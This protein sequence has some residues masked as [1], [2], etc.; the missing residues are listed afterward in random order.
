MD[1]VEDEVGVGPD[2]V[3]LE[4]V[5]LTRAVADVRERGL[6]VRRD[7]ELVDHPGHVGGDL[8]QAR[9]AAPQLGHVR[10]LD[11]QPAGAGLAATRNHASNG[12]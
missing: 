1:G 2:R 8:L 3:R 12:A 7:A 9:L 11:E 10:G 6:E 5:D 4:A